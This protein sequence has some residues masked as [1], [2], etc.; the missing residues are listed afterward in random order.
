MAKVRPFSLRLGTSLAQLSEKVQNH[1][2]SI[3]CH[4]SRVKP[5]EQQMSGKYRKGSWC[6]LESQPSPETDHEHCVNINMPTNTYWMKWSSSSTKNS[7]KALQMLQATSNR[8]VRPA[9]CCQPV[10]VTKSTQATHSGICVSKAASMT[11]KSLAF[12]GWDFWKEA[13]W[14]SGQRQ[15]IYKARICS[16][17]SLSW[18]YPAVIATKHLVKLLGAYPFKR[19]A[20]ALHITWSNRHVTVEGGIRKQRFLT[21]VRGLGIRLPTLKTP[22][23]SEGPIENWLT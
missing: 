12:L 15:Q 3:G 19:F 1:A 16:G 2:K 7:G 4:A 10:K 23:L 14:N 18:I 13:T 17:T 9:W 20:P 6:V 8:L 21:S 22:Q 5:M 11:E